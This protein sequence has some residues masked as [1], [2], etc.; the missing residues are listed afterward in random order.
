MLLALALSPLCAWA[1]QPDGGEA[2]DEVVR[3]TSVNTPYSRAQSL[4]LSIPFGLSSLPYQPDGFTA[5]EMGPP[6]RLGYEADFFIRRVMIILNTNLFFARYEVAPIV[7]FRARFGVNLRVLDL[8]AG[9]EFT[10]QQALHGPFSSSSFDTAIWSP[11]I[12]IYFPSYRL[13]L[14]SKRPFRIGL[15]IRL[16]GLSNVDLAQYEGLT[17]Q[18]QHSDS[19]V[20]SVLADYLFRSGLKISGGLDFYSLGS[21][22]IASKEF[23]LGISAQDRTREWVKAAY[24]EGSWE[25][26]VGVSHVEAPADALAIAYQAPFLND[27]YQLDPW[28]L[29]VGTKWKF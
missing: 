2:P 27:D 9:L 18:L 16:I 28:V 23:A 12:E 22:A 5:T 20:E 19:S 25:P 13:E 29:S 17:T 26:Y 14:D 4:D 21:A 15:G 24:E 11:S 8:I 3:T 10:D 7:D 6:F 1:A